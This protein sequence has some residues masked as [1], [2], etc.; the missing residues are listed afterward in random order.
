MRVKFGKSYQREQA[1]L[2]QAWTRLRAACPSFNNTEEIALQLQPLPRSCKQSTLQIAITALISVVIASSLHGQA[3][4]ATDSLTA[5]T[6]PADTATPEAAVPTTGTAVY[7]MTFVSTNPMGPTTKTLDLTYDFGAKKWAVPTGWTSNTDYV[8]GPGS[9][10]TIVKVDTTSGTTVTA[11]KFVITGT[12]TIEVPGVAVEGTSAANNITSFGESTNSSVLGANSTVN[13][14]SVTGNTNSMTVTYSAGA[15]PEGAV[16]YTDLMGAVDQVLGVAPGTSV[17]V[18]SADIAPVVTTASAGVFNGAVTVASAANGGPTAA[19]L[20]GGSYTIEANGKVTGAMATVDQT[21]I[22]FAKITGTATGLTAGGEVS[23][24]LTTSPS[25]SVVASTG[26]TTVGGTLSVIG[27]TTL[28][29]AL[30]AN[31]GTSTTTL[32]VTGAS[33]TNG[34]TNTGNINNSGAVK[35]ATLAVSGASTTTGITNTGDIT[36]SGAVKTATLVVS[37]ASTT[38]GITNTG[39]INNS[40]SVNTSTLV[41]TGATTTTGITNTGNITNSGA[42]NTATLVVTGAT[43][44]T[45]ITNTGNINN[46]GAVNTATLVVTGASTTTGITNTGD[47]KTATLTSTG[48][49]TIGGALSV[50]GDAK[51]AGSATIGGGLRVGGIISGVANGLAPNDAVNIGQL[52]DARRELARGI[53]GSSALAGIPQV[54]P[55]KTFSL[56][57]GLGTYSGESAIAIGISARY[58]NNM[59]AKAAISSTSGGKAVGSAG[60]GFSW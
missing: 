5:V 45:G 26:D 13:G 51:I 19:S 60:F 21:G 42:V 20:Q 48:N 6:T 1:G 41:V 58:T 25:F 54:D 44:T 55:S 32:V 18:K 50:A 7:T 31:G 29:G 28:T 17:T 59:I 3:R 9:V 27:A 14:G 12:P 52:G 49:A 2:R 22:N 47:I 15:L 56:G 8:G 24:D 39:N 33:M 4:A 11:D 57:A 36:N 38:T 35:T 30:T 34:I 46:S 23:V 53:A 16:Q 40:G 10:L 37:G 43:T